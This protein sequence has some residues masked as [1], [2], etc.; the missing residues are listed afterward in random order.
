MP[1]RIVAIA[2]GVAGIYVLAGLGW[3]LLALAVLVE[4]GWPRERSPQLEVV[5]QRALAS[6][7]RLVMSVRAMPQQMTGAS[8]VVAGVAILPAGAGLVTGRVGAA[9]LVL[10]ALLL[11][12]G[13]LLDRASRTE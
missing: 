3:A 7:R 5:F 11:S 4:V 6:G 2:A 12:L 9:L 10:G 1:R 13:L 8:A